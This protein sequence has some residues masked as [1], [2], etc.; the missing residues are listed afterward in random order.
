MKDKIS[1]IV[2]VYNVE[3]YLPKCIESILNQTHKNLELI[4]VDD[5]SP[6]GSPKICDEYAEKDKRVKVIHKKNAGVSAARN[7]GLD[8]AKGDFIA[9]VDSDDW[10]EQDMYEKLI[11]KQQENDYDLVMCNFNWVIDGKTTHMYEGSKKEFCES[12]DIT[13]I[14]RMPDYK[15]VGEDKFVTNGNINCYTAKYLYRKEVLKNIR[16]NT[17]LTYSEDIRF[18]LEIFLNKDLKVGY[19]ED[20][21]Y[22]YFIRK[23]SLSQG[24]VNNLVEKSQKFIDSVTE[25]LNG[26]EYENLIEAQKFFYY[27]ITAVN[28]IRYNT[29]DDLSSIES[30]NNK[31]TYKAHKVL[32]NGLK[33]KIKAFLVHKRLW[34]VFKLG[35]K[36]KKKG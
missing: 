23:A 34:F 31:K 2:P 35:I 28:K 14:L 10:I 32:C 5:G 6:D 25:L 27:Y 17:N 30:W 36:L 33:S 12:K 18:L 20:C 15:A 8:A 26:T 19:I 3:E 29:D 24:R 11:L 1:V 22:N 21:M 13:Y 7:D 4:L 9:F 16:F